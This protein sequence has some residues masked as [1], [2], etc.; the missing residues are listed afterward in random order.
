MA[1]VNGKEYSWVS[2]EF[3]AN[4]SA[5]IL[6]FT[7]IS[8]PWKVDAAVVRGAGRKALGTTRG[9]LMTEDGSI[10]LLES[11]Y[12]ELS[13]VP[14]W[15]D[16]TGELIV[17]YAEPGLPTLVDTIRGVRFT[18]ADAGGEEGN[19]ALKREVGFIFT[20]VLLDGVSPISE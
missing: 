3:R 11:D 2:M 18:G 10:T 12:R 13:S 6:G 19:E 15:C 17:S 14:G 8:Y 16:R 20:D 7:K 5:A 9:R 1:F 4:G